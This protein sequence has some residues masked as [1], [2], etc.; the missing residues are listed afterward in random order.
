MTPDPIMD[1]V[2]EGLG[3]YT[4]CSNNPVR[5]LDPDGMDDLYYD[6]EG[7][8]KPDIYNL[9]TGDVYEIKSA[10]DAGSAAPHLA[11]KM[12]ALK[13]A[14]LK[15]KPGDSCDPGV[16]A[17]FSSP[18]PGIILYEYHRG[19]TIR[20]PNIAHAPSRKQRQGLKL[21]VGGVT[22]TG[23]ALVIYLIISEG[24]RIFAPRNLIPVP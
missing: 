4:Y 3:V 24:S 14:G 22:I 6:G 18:A 13:A 8:L 2:I 15:M 20:Q 17:T 1:G 5:Y 16:Y 21:V 10:N 11:A 23:T 12:A 19:S 9:D 7:R